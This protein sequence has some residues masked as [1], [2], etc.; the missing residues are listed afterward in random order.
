MEHQG[1]PRRRVACEEPVLGEPPGLWASGQPKR[2]TQATRDG[3]KQ[4]W[5]CTGSRRGDQPGARG[6]LTAGAR[7]SLGA[8][9]SCFG[10]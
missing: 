10:F 8:L 4:V 2:Q 1:L 6:Q 5:W 9:F 7:Q 3:L